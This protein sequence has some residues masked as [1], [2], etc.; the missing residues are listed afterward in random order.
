MI[1]VEPI[2]GM[3]LPSN[4]AISIWSSGKMFRRIWFWQL[5]IVRKLF[6]KVSNARGKQGE[7]QFEE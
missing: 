7:E 6:R 4:I 5:T 3:P 2:T 1:E